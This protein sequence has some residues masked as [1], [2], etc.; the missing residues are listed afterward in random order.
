MR[1][2]HFPIYRF[3]VILA[4][5]Q[6]LVV[7]ENHDAIPENLMLLPIEAHHKFALNEGFYN[8]LLS[9]CS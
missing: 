7:F 3:S 6:D 1:C 8:V 4:Y 2:L 5:K 9:L